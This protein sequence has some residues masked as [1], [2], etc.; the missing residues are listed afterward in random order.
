MVL[1]FDFI[2]CGALVGSVERL[3]VLQVW[4]DLEA[5]GSLTPRILIP[6]LEGSIGEAD[7]N[8]GAA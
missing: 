1:E 5:S 3:G 2:E 4:D 8:C 7:M 6:S